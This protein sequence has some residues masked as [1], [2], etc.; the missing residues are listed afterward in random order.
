GGAAGAQGLASC[1]AVNQYLLAQGQPPADL[2]P[3]SQLAIRNDQFKLVQLQQPNC[4]TGQDETV[5]EFYEINELPGLPKIDR[6]DGQFTNNLLTTQP[7]LTPIQRQNF[8]SLSAQLQ[9]LLDSQPPP[10]PG[11]GNLDLLVN[12]E[13]LDNW[14]FFST[15]NNGQSS[16][17]DFNHDGLTDEQD[18]AMILD[19]F[20]MKCPKK[21]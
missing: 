15:N 17:Y 18:M 12:A 4:D 14:Q 6:P 13:D 21:N 9:K 20:E 11:D 16:W 3:D 1:C 2:L 19:N 10:C 8:N 7:N 5:T